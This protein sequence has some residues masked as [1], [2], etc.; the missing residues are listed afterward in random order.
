MKTMNQIISK[1]HQYIAN[2]L[3]DRLTNDMHVVEACEAQCRHPVDV[4]VM[5]TQLNQGFRQVFG[6]GGETVV[7]DI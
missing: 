2:K 4:V 5:D 7:R 1:V 3:A 6:N